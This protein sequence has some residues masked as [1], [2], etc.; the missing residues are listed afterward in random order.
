MYDTVKRYLN[1][2]T[3]QCMIFEQLRNEATFIYIYKMS[4][5]NERCI[6]AFGYYVRLF[7]ILESQ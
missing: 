2:L 7:C 6:C 1:E 3:S 4:N 5:E